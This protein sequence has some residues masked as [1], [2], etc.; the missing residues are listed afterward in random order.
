LK[1]SAPEKF[2]LDLLGQRMTLRLL[3]IGFVVATIATFTGAVLP[4]SQ[5]HGVDLIPWD[6]AEHFIA[7]FTLTVLAAT[8]F[9]ATSLL[10]IAVSLSAFGALI[11]IVQGLDFV[12]R[13]RDFWDWVADTIAIGAVVLSM[14]V[15]RWRLVSEE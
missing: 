15:A 11:E 2:I 1:L 3:R 12:G 7:F 13:D 5:L 4:E 9:P 8:A 6:K 10:R 14:L